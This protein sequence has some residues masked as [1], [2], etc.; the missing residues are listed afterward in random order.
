VAYVQQAERTPNTTMTMLNLPDDDGAVS[1]LDFDWDV[2]FECEATKLGCAYWQAR[3]AGRTMPRREDLDPVAMRKFTQHVGL[4][5]IRPGPESV[6]YYI[7]RAGT[8]WEDV[9][10]PITGHCLYEFLPPELEICWRTVF[11]SVRSAK[12]PVRIT[13]KIDYQGKNWL[14][15]EFLVAPLGE[16]EE[17]TMLFIVFVSW[18]EHFQLPPRSSMLHN[19]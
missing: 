8:R 11:D 6:D 15:T 12:A 3:R 16:G 19:T 4:V 17:P 14:N 9:Y 5:E 10:G 13:T 2:R 18:G 7:R 1:P